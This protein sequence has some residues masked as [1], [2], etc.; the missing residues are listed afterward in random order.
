MQVD[1]VRLLA[2][3]L[4]SVVCAG[5][6]SQPE[7]PE[8][9]ILVNHVGFTPGAAKFC[10]VKGTAPAKFRLVSVDGNDAVFTGRLTPAGGDFEGYLVGE[11]TRFERSGMYRVHCAQRASGPFRIAPDVYRDGVQ[12]AVTYLSIQRC[13]PSTTGYHHPCHLDDGRRAD[14]GAHQDVTGGWHDACDLRRWV[15]ATIYGMIGLSRVAEA[16]PAPDSG[17]IVEE[18]QWGNHYFLAMQ[19]PAGYVMSFCG[20]DFKR[21]GDDNRWTDNVPGNED[22]RHIAV[23]PVD[24]A[25]QYCFIMA[26]AAVVRMTR[27][28][29]PAYARKCEAAARRCLDW[30]IREKAARTTTDLGAAAAA[31]AEMYRTFHEP[32]F[33]ELAA[34]FGRQVMARQVTKRPDNQTPIRGFFRTSESDPRPL[35]EIYRGPWGLLGLCSLAETF[36]DQGD[37]PRWRSAIRMYCG[38]YLAAMAPRNGFGIVPYAMY[39]G[40]APG[41]RHVGR[42]G[43]RYFFECKP[44][45]WVGINANVASAG[46]GLVWASRLLKEPAWASLAQ[47][48]LD[49]ILGVN[50][51]DASTMEDVGRNQPKQFRTSEFNPITPH[52]PGAV[53]NGIGGTVDDRPSLLPGHWQTCEYWTPMTCYTMWLMTELEGVTEADSSKSQ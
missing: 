25:A 10:L 28:S 1:L 45:W 52:I 2:A 34:D 24:A 48:Q 30:C 22:D 23:G 53:M 43:Y 9:T 35:A 41:G 19:E 27:Q 20:G 44:E 6:S 26:Q 39:T 50:P 32:R 46:V 31:C 14:T 16:F 4:L 7:A 17:K 11:F 5:A 37:A 42:Y 33:A 12:K 15:T 18:L 40:Q 47:R 51:F 36:P 3:L 8:S 29:D 13:G 38:D 21:H 49:W